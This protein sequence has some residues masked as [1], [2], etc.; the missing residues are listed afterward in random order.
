[1]EKF[2]KTVQRKHE[3]PRLKQIYKLYKEVPRLFMPNI[4]QIINKCY[5][6]KRLLEYFKIAKILGLKVES[7]KFST[8]L[9]SLSK[10][11]QNPENKN[12]YDKIIGQISEYDFSEQ[13]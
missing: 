8:F 6:R 3:L 9:L 2:Y 5:H 12:N 4:E 13:I 1:M 7:I 10:S 11:H